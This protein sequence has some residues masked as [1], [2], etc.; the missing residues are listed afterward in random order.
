AR[1][2]GSGNGVGGMR[3]TA[4]LISR[5]V[6]SD[7]WPEI[8]GSLGPM[9]RSVTDA[10]KLMDVMIGY[11]PEDPLTALGVGHVSGSYTKFLDKNG[12]KGAR[13]GVLRESMGRYSEPESQDFAKVTT[14]FN[15][16]MKELRAAGAVLVDPIVIPNLNDLLKARAESPTERADAFKVF[17]G[18]SVHPPFQT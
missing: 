8:N 13:I 1:R 6:V 17:F 11:D 15:E 16:A 3:P 10:A 12:L 18:R 5:S 14:V 7:G 9:T 2:R 4:G